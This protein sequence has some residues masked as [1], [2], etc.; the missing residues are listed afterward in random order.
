[1][2]R[3][4]KDRESEIGPVLGWLRKTGL[5]DTVS[6]RLALCAQARQKQSWAQA[7]DL[8][9]Q[10]IKQA[11][12]SDRT[13]GNAD[14]LAGWGRMY[15]G[16]VYYCQADFAQ[17]LDHFDR[18]YS[19]FSLDTTNQRVAQFARGAACA[20]RGDRTG[21]DQ[22]V[23]PG[24]MAVLRTMGVRDADALSKTLESQLDKSNNVTTA[25]AAG[26][27]DPPELV[28]DQ[29]QSLQRRQIFLDPDAAKQASVI[30]QLLPGVGI[31]VVAAICAAA[32][33]ELTGTWYALIA[34]LVTWALVSYLLVRRLRQVIPPN[35]ALVIEKSS[36]PAVVWG[37]KTHYRWPILERVHALVPL[38]T[39]RYISPKKTIS[40][41]ADEA[42]EVRVSVYYGVMPMD[43]EGKSV[44]SAV[45]NHHADMKPAKEGQT[46]KR[47]KAGALD[48]NQIRQKWEG[49][50]LSDIVMT[51]NEVLPGW[52]RQRLSGNE[53][54]TR[55]LLINWVRE[56]LEQRVSEWGMVIE[57][58][59]IIEL[60]KTKA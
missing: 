26:K 57:E 4:A 32:V 34:Y 47:S 28:R 19:E 37:P 50:L 42:V 59:N 55:T 40:L 22:S 23:T 15:L 30:A 46:S 3:G 31:I 25:P 7:I 17:A 11:K 13:S 1:M 45:Y 60:N 16:A 33:K 54:S 35:H 18:A 12:A 29:L 43:H 39:V 58:L 24:L 41:T 2:D 9:W 20:K 49:R 8:C 14:S 10:V 53:A 5:E 38:G 51:L 52:T 56:R 21:F 44:L 6:K 48:V 36:V 27:F